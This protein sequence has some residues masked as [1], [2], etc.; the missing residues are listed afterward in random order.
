MVGLKESFSELFGNFFNSA[1]DEEKSE[2]RNIVDKKNEF[3]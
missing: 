3:S 2:A 1:T